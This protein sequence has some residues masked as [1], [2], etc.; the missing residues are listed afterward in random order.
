MTDNAMSVTTKRLV[1]ELRGVISKCSLCG[2]T[3]C[4]EPRILNEVSSNIVDLQKEVGELR[5]RLERAE[6]SVERLKLERSELIK[7]ITH[8]CRTCKHIHKDQ[9]RYTCD[10]SRNPYLIGSYCGAWEWK[11]ND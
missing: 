7:L 8:D 6:S 11:M 5:T 4:Q 9:T 1:Q 2:V 10:L 3:S